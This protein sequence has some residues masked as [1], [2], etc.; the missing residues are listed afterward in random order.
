LK[1]E[2]RKKENGGVKKAYERKKQDSLPVLNLKD[3]LQVLDN[4]DVQ[5]VEA[6]VDVSS[7]EGANLR[8]RADRLVE[9]MRN[10]MDYRF[11]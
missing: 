1:E 2:A 4:E 10:K 6:H 5:K 9:L 7:V 11:M 3:F 8:E